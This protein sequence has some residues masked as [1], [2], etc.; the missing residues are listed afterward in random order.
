MAPP[1]PSAP[2]HAARSR[3]PLRALVGALAFALLSGGLGP[4]ASAAPGVR[5]ASAAPADPS[6][7]NGTAAAI[8]RRIAATDVSWAASP[9][10]REELQR[11]YQPGAY[12]PLWFD[13]QGRPGRNIRTALAL[14][15]DAGTEGLHPA[16]Y[17]ARALAGQAE[18]LLADGRADEPELA[19]LDVGLSRG[20]LRYL[21]HLH[22]GRVD[23]RT[24][25]FRV[26]ALPSAPDFTALLHDALARQR[27]RETAEQL[28]PVTSQYR[29]LRQM[30][31]RY[32]ELAVDPALSAPLPALAAPLRPGQPYAGLPQLHARLLRYG[33]LPERTPAP[34]PGAPYEGALVEGVK[35]FQARH[36]LASNGQLGKATL[37]ALNVT[38]AGRV[39]QI[40]LAMERLRWLRREGGRPFLAINIP[41]YRLAAWEPRAS[42]NAGGAP[43]LNMNVIVGRALNTQTP[44]LAEEMRYLVFRPYWNVPRSIVRDEILPALARNPKYLQR[45]NMELV[46]GPGDDAAPVAST[47]ENL[48]RLRRGELRVRQRPGPDNALGLVKFIFPNDEAVYLHGTP[49]QGLFARSRR[50][51]SHGCVRLEDPVTLAEWLLKDQPEWTRKRIEAAMAGKQPLRVNLRQPVPVLLYYITA[52]VAPEDGSLHFAQDIYGH[53]QKLLRALARQRPQP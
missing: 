33:D 43:A 52:A 44:V 38:P 25:G 10:E 36:T 14:L 11:L 9:A 19:A 6:L 16:D 8:E 30:L 48:D 23:P 34:A 18:R 50:D 27:L 46:Q 40:E 31:A 21:R 28:T 13:A 37:A 51:F 45:K 2:V 29:E 22:L 42:A 26:P 5:V 35:R 20:M 12:A 32:R 41:M 47:P 17:R 1:N 4:A 39:T 24:L 3:T 7:A 15:A 53:D 49:S